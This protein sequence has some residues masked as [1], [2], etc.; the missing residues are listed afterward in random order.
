MRSA[1]ANT[2]CR[3]SLAQ[4]GEGSAALSSNQADELQLDLR[5]L[6]DFGRQENPLMYID[7]YFRILHAY[8]IIYSIYLNIGFPIAVA[9]RSSVC[10]EWAELVHVVEHIFWITDSVQTLNT[11]LDKHL[12]LNV[13]GANQ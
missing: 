6:F 12:I 4:L 13:Y 10:T 3:A 1:I 5:W 2:P 7:V 8:T 11:F 9:H